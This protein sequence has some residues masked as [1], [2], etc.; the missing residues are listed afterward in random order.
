M[1]YV[2]LNVFCM[3]KLLYDLTVLDVMILST[4]QIKKLIKGE[5]KEIGMMERFAAG[6]SA[7]AVAQTCVYPMEV[8]RIQI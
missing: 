3:S 7:G 1:D 8:G 2:I 4:L 6:S 5:S